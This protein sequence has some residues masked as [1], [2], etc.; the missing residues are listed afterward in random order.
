MTKDKIEGVAEAVAGIVK[1]VPIYQDA[2][3]PAAKE[4]GK[5]LKT[6]GGVIN[7]ALAPVAAMVFG[8]NVIKEGLNKRL[9]KRL[10][11]ISPED[12]IIPKLQV[13]GPLIEKYKYVYDSKELSQ[14]FINLLANAMDKNRVQKAHPSF[15]NV[16]SELSP[17]EAKLIETIAK[18]EILPKLDVRIKSKT[19][20]S[21][22]YH[23]VYINFTLLG[24]KAK[25]Q[26]PDLTPSY[27]SN[28]ERLNIITCPFG[29]FQEKYVHEELYKPLQEHKLINDFRKRYKDTHDLE[30]IQGI[31]R[32]TDFGEMF[33]EAVLDSGQKVR[34][35]K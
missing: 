35:V 34:K 17:D 32:K 33:I 13:V 31:I 26:Y 15:V 4:V 23:Y 29:D 6:V 18:E 8:F 24:E 20:E 10:S 28:L 2:V 12:I 30:T 11:T 9:E 16:I 3:Q 19:A 22:G 14:M 27:L 7:V 1:A 21:K 5:A 25:L